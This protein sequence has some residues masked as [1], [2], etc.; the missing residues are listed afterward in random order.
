[1]AVVQP[2]PVSPDLLN[3]SGNSSKSVDYVPKIQILRR[4]DFHLE[5][6]LTPMTRLTM[7]IFSYEPRAFHIYCSAHWRSYKYFESSESPQVHDCWNM[8]SARNIHLAWRPR[9]PSPRLQ[10]LKSWHSTSISQAPAHVLAR[11][12]DLVLC[13]LFRS[14]QLTWRWNLCAPDLQMHCRDLTLTQL[15]LVLHICS[16]WIGS[17]LVQIMACR[18]FGAKPLS[19]PMQ[20]YCQLEP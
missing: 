4:N 11:T 10:W 19:K 14:L 18:L 2:K 5:D 6:F 17:A 15:P 12:A 7:A 8:D 13:H 9:K 1:M 16:Q 20:G 3:V